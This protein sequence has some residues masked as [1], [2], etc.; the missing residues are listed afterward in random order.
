MSYNIMIIFMDKLVDVC[1]SLFL[2]I[3]SVLGQ[4]CFEAGY[5]PIRSFAQVVSK[6]NN[7]VKNA[8]S[9]HIVQCKHGG[10]FSKRTESK[11]YQIIHSS[12]TSFLENSS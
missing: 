7:H 8:N 9:R 6:Y 2:C 3:I 11:I 1:L 4:K 12:F 5:V 10:Q